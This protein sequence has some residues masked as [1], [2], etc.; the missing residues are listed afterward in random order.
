MNIATLIIRVTASKDYTARISPEGLGEVPIYRKGDTKTIY[1][2]TGYVTHAFFYG[3][4]RDDRLANSHIVRVPLVN[5]T[6]DEKGTSERMKYFVT[7]VQ[8]NL[9]INNSYPLEF[10]D[11]AKGSRKNQILAN[12]R[13]LRQA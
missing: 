12:I 7:S 1:I 6:V 13:K 2:A 10:L 3:I 11:D 5:C 4:I 8:D 9:E